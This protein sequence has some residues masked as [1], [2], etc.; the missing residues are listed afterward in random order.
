M[1]MTTDRRFC[2]FSRRLPEEGL[3]A[4]YTT[5]IPE[6]GLCLSSFVVMEDSE[7]RVLMG[8]LDPAAPWDHIGALDPGRAA[9]HG[10]GWMLPS[11]HLM[12]YESPQEAAQRIMKEQLGMSVDLMGPT[13]VAEVGTPNRFPE[14]RNHWDFEFIF[15]G[16]APGGEPP[17]HRAW[18]EL[19]YVDLKRTPRGEVARSHDDVLENA[20]Y[21]F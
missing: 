15:R 6:G 7:G 13:V 4:L 10:K 14:L 21:T 19:R 3:A 5:E 16:D 9:A 8:H 2:R 20:G 1:I 11:S 18:K 17:T 12:L